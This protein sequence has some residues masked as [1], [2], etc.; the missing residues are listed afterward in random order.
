M[1]HRAGIVRRERRGQ[2]L[3]EL[4]LALPL[5]FMLL[6][7]LIEIGFMIKTKMVLQ[8]AVREAARY[9]GQAGTLDGVPSDSGSATAEGCLADYTVLSEIAARLQGSVVNTAH[10]RAIFLY[11]ANNDDNTPRPA[12]SSTGLPSGSPQ[13]YPNSGLNGDYYYANYSTATGADVDTASAPAGSGDGAVYKLFNNNINGI[14]SSAAVG[15]GYPTSYTPDCGSSLNQTG[16]D[17]RGNTINCFSYDDSHTSG[18]LA[19]PAFGTCLLSDSAGN[20]PPAWRDN[21]TDW[22]SSSGTRWPDTFGV[23]IVYDYQFQ[24]PLFQAIS[25]LF[26]GGSHFFRM[27]EHAVFSMDPKV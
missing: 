27:D 17:A 8:D 25:S 13:T 18:N 4:A 11:A 14:F 1:H 15:S 24:T 20:W 3:A 12:L 6:L 26:L 5:L 21:V 9:G 10:V 2:A 16:Q 23:D 7:G 22:D 19:G